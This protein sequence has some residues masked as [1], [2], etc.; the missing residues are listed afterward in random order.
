LAIARVS[1][2]D[3]NLERFESR[4]TIGNQQS[5]IVEF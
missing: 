1:I 2:A 5:A 3:F 4:R